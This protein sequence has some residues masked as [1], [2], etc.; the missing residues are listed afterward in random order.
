MH[1]LG[2]AAPPKWTLRGLPARNSSVSGKGWILDGVE[3]ADRLGI[4][5]WFSDVGL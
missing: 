3:T 4:K 2:K 1:C 5:S